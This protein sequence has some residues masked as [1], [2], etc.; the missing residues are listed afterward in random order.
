MKNRGSRTSNTSD[1]CTNDCV[2]IISMEKKMHYSVRIRNR[3]LLAFK[4]QSS[5]ILSYHTIHS[6]VEWVNLAIIQVVY[7]YM[8]VQ[9]I[10]HGVWVFTISPISLNSVHKT[11]TDFH[12]SRILIVF[13]YFIFTWNCRAI[14]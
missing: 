13:L 4:V 11:G 9:Y 5:R 1:C 10:N 6:V 2:F 14:W 12:S 7:V 8:Y 3:W